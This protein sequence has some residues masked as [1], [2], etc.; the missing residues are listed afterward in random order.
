MKLLALYSGGIA[1]VDD[2]DFEAVS[3]YRWRL[4]QPSHPRTRSARYAVATI[5][6]RRVYLH[7]WLWARWGML[8]VPIVEHRNTDGLDCTRINLRAATV[9]QNNRNRGKLRTNKTGYKGVR[10][11]GS[12]YRAEIT[13][14][15]TRRHLGYFTNPIEAARAH[16]A[17]ARE[18]HGEFASLNGA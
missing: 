15:N 18:H 2:E 3:Q 4:H 6:G 5:D 13:V 11:V 1:A 9:A 12:R 17:A 10:K 16:D 8:P 14:D 7:L